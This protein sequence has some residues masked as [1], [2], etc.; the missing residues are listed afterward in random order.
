MVLGDPLYRDSFGTAQ[1]S[2]FNFSLESTTT[3]SPG[4]YNEASVQ[5]IV[6]DLFDD[7]NE[8]GDTVSI[9]YAPMYDVFLNTLRTGVPLT[10]L[11]PFITSL[12]RQPGVPVAGVDT[13]V[14]AEGVPGTSL[15]I[16]SVNMTDYATT[17]THSGVSATSADLVLPIYSSITPNGASVR[18]CGA[19]E[20]DVPGG[21]VVGSDNKLGNRRFLRFTLPSAR[22]LR[23]R[24]ECQVS[25]PTCGGTPT[26]DPDFVLT[27]GLLGARSE[28]GEPYVE[29]NVFSVTAGDY[30][31][32]IY[33]Y[34]HVDTSMDDA[35]RRGRTCMTV[36]ITG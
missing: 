22:N 8:A 19:S 5:R 24:V 12:K 26:P 35:D 17:E 34:S 6:W 11:F 3:S 20:L 1:G 9:G 10:S 21:S 25:D 23:V 29:E 7:V 36:T 2:D 13:R 15:G 18:V 31:L 4:W 14:Q 27:S 28:S 33:E 16:D 30:V 32:E